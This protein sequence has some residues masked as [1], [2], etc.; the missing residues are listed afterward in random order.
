MHSNISVGIKM[1]NT[2]RH[3]KLDMHLP[4]LE[5]KQKDVSAWIF[6]DC[7]HAGPQIGMREISV[8]D[9]A[10]LNKWEMLVLWY[11]SNVHR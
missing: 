1:H 8:K 2:W 6:T 4:Y 5:E 7:P 10:S 9:N 3:H 11:R